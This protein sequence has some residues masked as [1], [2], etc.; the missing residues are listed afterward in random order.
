MASITSK[1]VAPLAHDC[2][3][4]LTARRL[5]G[6]GSYKLEADRNL[7]KRTAFDWTILRPGTLTEEQ[8]TGRISLGKTRLASVTVSALPLWSSGG[9]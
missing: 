5:G 1:P 4:T 9:P 7:S 6:W 8:G 2:Q 3:P